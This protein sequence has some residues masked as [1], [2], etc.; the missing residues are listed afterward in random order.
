MLEIQKIAKMRKALNLTQKELA[1]ISGVSQSLIAKIESGS[2]DPA[3]SKVSQILSSLEDLNKKDK[4]TAKDIL[5]SSVV[6]ASPSDSLFDAISLMQEKGLS[7]LPVFQ[8]GRSVGSLL[9][10]TIVSIISKHQ[11]KNLKSM[12]VG[13]VMREG[14]PLIPISSHVDAIA[15]LLRHYRAI[16]VEQ[17]GKIVG[18]IT[19]A[20]LFK[21]I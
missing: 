8:N 4:K 16:L 21:A 18:I 17:N 6:F 11:E 14:F 15:D 12:N 13:E 1:N 20:D 10:S 3:Y 5:T 2:I 19:K 9:D 7:Q